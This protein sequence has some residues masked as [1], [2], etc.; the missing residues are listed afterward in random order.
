MVEISNSGQQARN[1]VAMRLRS[2]GDALE[3]HRVKILAVAGLITLVFLSV[4]P[5]ILSTY[6]LSLLILTLIYSFLGSS[7]NVLLG[8]AGLASL[9][10]GAFFGAAAYVVAILTTQMSMPIWLAGC[11]GVLGAIVAGA[12]LGLAVSH[13][14]VHS[15]FLASLAAGM[16]VWGVA[17]QWVSVTGGDNGISGIPRPELFGITFHGPEMYYFALVLYVIALLVLVLVR[18]SPFGYSL[19]ALR[20]NETRMRALGYKPWLHQYM[21]YI[22]AAAIAGAGGALYATYNQYVSPVSASVG[23]SLDGLLMAIIGGRGTLLGPFLGAAVI[24]IVGQLISGYTQHWP[25]VL[26]GLYVL[27]VLYLPNGLLGKRVRKTS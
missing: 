3:G 9:G 24:V 8:Q 2:L 12:V 17:Y 11:A 21:G 14:R 15:F 1:T 27:V 6:I 10:Q 22:F 19:N 25:M 23:M 20:E 16:V 26:G 5:W 4:A 18:R 7:A 13:L